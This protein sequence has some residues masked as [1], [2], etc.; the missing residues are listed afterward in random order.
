M[1]IQQHTDAVVA[2][3]RRIWVAATPDSVN[4][5][6]RRAKQMVATLPK[7]ADRIEADRL[8]VSLERLAFWLQD[9]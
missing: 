5:D 1:A 2:E 6:V 3:L 9:R 4:E 7:G 8:L